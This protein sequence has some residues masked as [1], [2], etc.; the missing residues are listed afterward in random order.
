M[1]FGLSLSGVVNSIKETKDF[2]GSAVQFFTANPYRMEKGY[3]ASFKAREE[4]S[5]IDHNI[6][7][8]SHGPLSI[9][10]VSESDKTRVYSINQT[11]AEIKRAQILGINSIV[12]HP[13]S[14][15]EKDLKQLQS[16]ILSIKETL[17][18]YNKPFDRTILI[19]NMV[20]SGN[21]IMST[22]EE[23]VEFFSET[24]I[25]YPSIYENLGICL[26][27]AHA[28]G[29]GFSPLEFMEVLQKLI[30]YLLS[31]KILE[32]IQIRLKLH[33]LLGRNPLS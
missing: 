13:G 23:F 1:K 10:L 11:V 24:K 6:E 2:G 25:K 3:D 27:T 12:L 20:G 33:Y 18:K 19:E 28:W 4:L 21:Q 5:L 29:A 30:H 32:R 22:P 31:L 14:N 8:I 26:D 16:S 9:N 17:E 7:M 15:E